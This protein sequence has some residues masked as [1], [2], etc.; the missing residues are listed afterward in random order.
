MLTKI[1][2]REAKFISNNS[3]DKV[4]KRLD[5]YLNTQKLN[6]FLKCKSF[7]S[8][9]VQIQKKLEINYFLVLTILIINTIY[10]AILYQ[11]FFYI[12]I[13]ISKVFMPEDYSHEILHPGTRAQLTPFKIRLAANATRRKFHRK[14]FCH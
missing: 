11:T 1:I 4:V 6:I 13:G 7:T 12:T 2:K 8:K 5:S 10:R 3:Y 9:C 14:L